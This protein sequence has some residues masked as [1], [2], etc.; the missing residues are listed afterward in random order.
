[1]CNWCVGV[2]ECQ[3]C[4]CLSLRRLALKTLHRRL[5]KQEC[6]HFFVQT[7]P[8]SLHPE[9]GSR[10]SHTVWFYRYLIY[11]TFPRVSHMMLFLCC[12]HSDILCSLI[13]NETVKCKT[14][15]HWFS[16]WLFTR[17]IWIYIWRFIVKGYNLMSQFS[18]SC[19]CLSIS[20]WSDWPLFRH[21]NPLAA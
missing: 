2:E 19:S 11:E 9:P 15:K 17:Y 6:G 12:S 13:F 1:M 7:T 14:R 18:F 20:F 21:I 5:E 4:V 16:V 3:M 10:F 8:A